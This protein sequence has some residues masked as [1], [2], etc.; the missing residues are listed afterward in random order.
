MSVQKITDV[1]SETLTYIGEAK[2]GTAT[3][4]IGWS[5]KK[6]SVSSGETTEAWPV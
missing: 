4:E 2:P 3:T 1:V 5:I 6:V